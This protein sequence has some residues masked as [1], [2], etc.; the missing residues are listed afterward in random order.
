MLYSYTLDAD[1]AALDPQYRSHYQAY[2]NIYA[3]C[4]LPVMAV[5]SD[6]GMLGGS[7]AHEFMYLTPIGED[8]LLICDACG[9]AAN[10]Q[11]ARFRKPA[12]PV[13]VPAPVEEVATP[14]TTTIEALAALLGVPKART[15]KAVFLVA[16]FADAGQDVERFVFA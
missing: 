9:Y 13:E 16:T 6:V 12:V 10:R 11:I 3:R 15:A 5:A 8:T 14:A 7:L 1:P 4:G 2:F